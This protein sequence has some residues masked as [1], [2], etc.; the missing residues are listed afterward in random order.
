MIEKHVE[1]WKPIIHRVIESKAE[2]FRLFGYGD[3]TAETVWNCLLVK[4]WRKEKI[5]KL[6]EV[7]EDVF[8]LS[9]HL[10]MSYITM[11]TYQSDD[12]MASIAAV[13]DL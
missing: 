12:L 9:G 13:T 11:E 10:Y 1:D 4:V 6:H 3:V 5:M 2:E 8:H 7:V